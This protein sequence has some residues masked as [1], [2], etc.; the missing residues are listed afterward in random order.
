[1]PTLTP[2]IA[3]KK[4]IIII[5]YNNKCLVSDVTIT[6]L[7]SLYPSLLFCK[8]MGGNQSSRKEDWLQRETTLVRSRF[9]DCGKELYLTHNILRK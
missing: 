5:L 6:S 7:K 8:W 1:M 3:L 2:G 4:F 9:H